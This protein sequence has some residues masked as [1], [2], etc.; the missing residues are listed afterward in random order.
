MQRRF[1]GSSDNLR[2]PF[3]GPVCNQCETYKRR[4]KA[5]EAE[6]AIATKPKDEVLTESN[7]SNIVSN[8]SNESNMQS[9]TE[10]NTND[11]EVAFDKA[12]YQ[13]QYMKDQRE[14]KKLG[15]SI[16]DYRSQKSNS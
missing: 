9:N 16:Q 3:S 2:A 14:A 10:S 8:K 15:L 11:G 4:I 7:K 12:A 13:R 5:L 1:G 6:L